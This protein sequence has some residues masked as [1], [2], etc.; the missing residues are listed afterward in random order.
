MTVSADPMTTVVRLRIV[1]TNPPPGT[2]TSFGVQD[3]SGALH[4]EA[5]KS[6]HAV[7]FECEVKAADSRDGSGPNF[8]GPFTHGPPTARFLYISHRRDGAAGWIK[9]IKVPL[10]SITWSMIEKAGDRAIETEVDGRRSGTVPAMWR[11]IS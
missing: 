11:P 6:K 1:V 8:L 10:S 7:A 5:S 3:K 2:G 9:R 4:S